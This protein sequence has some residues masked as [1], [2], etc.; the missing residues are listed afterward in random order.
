MVT[1][2]ASRPNKCSGMKRDTAK[3]ANLQGRITSWHGET[4]RRREFVVLIGATV[5]WPFAATAASGAGLPPRRRV[6]QSTQ[7]AAFCFDVR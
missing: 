4:M 1:P 2:L 7:Y 3:N 5:A 6:L